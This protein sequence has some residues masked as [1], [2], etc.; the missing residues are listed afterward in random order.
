V[1]VTDALRRSHRELSPQSERFLDFVAAHPE[2]LLR[3][4]FATLDEVANAPLSSWPFFVGGS[5]LE[6]LKSSAAGITRLVKQI[7]ARV[8]R[9]DMAALSAFYQV[10]SPAMAAMI[11]A[12]PNGIDSAL[13]RVDL[14]RTAKGFQCLEVNFGGVGGIHASALAGVYERIPFLRRFLAEQPRRARCVNAESAILEHIVTEAQG[15]LSVRDAELNIA[16]LVDGGSSLSQQ[17]ALLAHFNQLYDAVLR[18]RAPSWKG[19]IVMGP[20]A[21]LEDRGDGLWMNGLQIGAILEWATGHRQ[22]AFR[23]WKARRLGLYNGPAAMI[24]SDKRNLAFL[25]ELESSPMLSE[26]ERD[27]VRRWVPWTRQVKPGFTHRDGARIHLADHVSARREGLVLKSARSGQG[28]DVHLGPGTSQEAW[29]RLLRDALSRRDW[30]VQELQESQ[31][32]L[33][34]Q[35]D[36]G[37]CVHDLV[38]GAFVF[39]SAYGGAFLRVLPQGRRQAINSAQG[40]LETVLFEVEEPL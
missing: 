8:F 10:A 26:E 25:S 9:G 33:C 3:S 11:L 12:E 18:E 36:A 1:E 30:V 5:V 32:Y 7:P 17:E 39:G 21:L 40:A 22:L 23:Y 24:L 38:W 19:C 2:G 6:E 31:P 34:P 13:A 37:A 20:A 16:F 28:Q 29:D 14:L 35:A 15:D 27:M 4:T